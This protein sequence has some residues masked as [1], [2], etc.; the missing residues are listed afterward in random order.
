MHLSDA[1]LFFF[2]VFLILT[3]FKKMGEKEM[4]GKWHGKIDGVYWFRITES[5]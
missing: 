3:G 4:L 2:F 5:Q 1:L